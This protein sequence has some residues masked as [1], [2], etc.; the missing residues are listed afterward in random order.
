MFDDVAR[1]S[2]FVVDTTRSS[3]ANQENRAFHL[4]QYTKSN[5]FA[6]QVTRRGF[7]DFRHFKTNGPPLESQ[8]LRTGK[9]QIANHQPV[10]SAFQLKQYHQN[11]ASAASDL[12][13][14]VP[15]LVQETSNTVP[16]NLGLL[17]NRIKTQIPPMQQR[18]NQVCN[19]QQ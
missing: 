3:Y 7:V 5:P 17:G 14:R 19:I 9:S 15:F 11:G 10:Q 12:Q 4:N 6:G 16:A 18:V 13:N 1:D 8:V 2:T